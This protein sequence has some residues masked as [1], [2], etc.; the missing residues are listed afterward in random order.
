MDIFCWILN[1]LQYSLATFDVNLVS[2]SDMN[3]LGAPYRVNTCFMINAATPSTV[4]DSLQGIR[5]IAFEQ[6]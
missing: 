5:I 2:Q 3:F 4:I 6:S 1:L